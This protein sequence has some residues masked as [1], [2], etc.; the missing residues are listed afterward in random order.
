[1]VGARGFEPPSRIVHLD[2]EGE[3]SQVLGSQCLLELSQGPGQ[4]DP[5][6]RV[7]GHPAQA[8]RHLCACTHDGTSV[9]DSPTKITLPQIAL[10]R[11]ATFRPACQPA[12]CHEGEILGVR[13]SEHVHKLAWTPDSTS[14]AVK[15]IGRSPTLRSRP[16]RPGCRRSRARRSRWGR[17]RTPPCRQG[18]TSRDPSGQSACARGCGCGSGHLRTGRF[19]R[20]ARRRTPAGTGLGPGG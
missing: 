9:W 3:G 10:S 4:R 6:L 2:A 18:R 14:P 5:V 17:L 1:M 7:Q 13:P 15:A 16:P 8:L 20:R 12:L 11:N 19:H